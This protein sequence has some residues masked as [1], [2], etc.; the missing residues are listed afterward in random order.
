MRHL[1]KIR[2]T[3][4]G[5][6]REQDIPL[7]EDSAQVYIVH[8]SVLNRQYLPTSFQFYRLSQ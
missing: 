3:N 5:K 6:I 2:E 7:T 4:G 1:N 8:K